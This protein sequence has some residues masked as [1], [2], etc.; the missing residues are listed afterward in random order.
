MK[1]KPNGEFGEFDTLVGRVLA[2]PHSVIQKRVA[3]ARELASQN[4]NKRGPKK[5]KRSTSTASRASSVRKRRV[6]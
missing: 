4:P 2:V 3:E 6:S 1:Q 5:R